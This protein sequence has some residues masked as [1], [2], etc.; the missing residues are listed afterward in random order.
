MNLCP[1]E[2]ALRPWLAAVAVATA[3]FAC[4]GRN[5]P[6]TGSDLNGATGVP[7]STTMSGASGGTTGGTG[8]GN[9]NDSPATGQN[10]TATSPNAVGPM[11]VAP[12]GATA[13]LCL[14]AS[15]D[16]P[17]D[18]SAVTLSACNDVPA[19]HWFYDRGRLVGAG[20]LCLTNPGAAVAAG[21][22]PSVGQLA[23]V[24]T[25]CNA[26]ASEVRQHVEPQFGAL[27]NVT[28]PS[29]YALTVI[30]ANNGPGQLFWANYDP[31]DTTQ[32]FS[33]GAIAQSGNAAASSSSGVAVHVAGAVSC[34]DANVAANGTGGGTVGIAPCD[35][36]RADQAWQLDVYGQLSSNGR[37][38][39]S[40]GGTL[41]LPAC[42]QPAPARQWQANY[43]QLVGSTR[44]LVASPATGGGTGT[45]SLA[46][47]DGNSAQLSFGQHP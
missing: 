16:A 1:L 46:A 14:A 3:T 29:T 39:D 5:P 15:S 21:S 26:N 13:P 38:L 43:G 42:G 31:N 24:L 47:C 8:A 19:Q 7:V 11:F 12:Y 23:A 45:L 20:N 44:C 40:S 30:K 32:A 33:L 34:L 4:A 22:V 28:G 27:M 37:C 41:S 36:T 17:T 25:A 10:S 18:G 6:S 9:G 35:V 2:S